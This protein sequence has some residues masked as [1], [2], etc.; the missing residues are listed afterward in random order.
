MNLPVQDLIRQKC[1][2]ADAKIET[3]NFKNK[4]S[5]FIKI[6]SFQLF[7]HFSIDSESP[8]IKF[9]KSGFKYSKLCNQVR[10]LSLF[11][12]RTLTLLKI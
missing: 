1:F 6:Y 4:K 8:D 7:V 9:L 11:R 2:L 3:F 5:H 12:L 10:S